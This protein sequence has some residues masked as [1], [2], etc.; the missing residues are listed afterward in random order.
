[1]CFGGKCHGNPFPAC[2]VT[3]G[4]PDEDAGPVRQH[5]CALLYPHRLA[6]RSGMQ[7]LSWLKAFECS[8]AQRI[9]IFI[10]FPTINREEVGSQSAP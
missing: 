4:S 2:H 8:L 1:M 6:P 5:P 3:V 10:A 7:A 9:L